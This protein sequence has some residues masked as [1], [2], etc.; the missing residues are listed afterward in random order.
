MLC[1]TLGFCVLTALVGV[2]AN[3]VVDGSERVVVVMWMTGLMY[4][5]CQEGNLQMSDLESELPR[6][7]SW[8]FLDE[9]PAGFI[10]FHY[11]GEMIKSEDY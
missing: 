2:G 7:K 1:F 4:S 11:F 6:R 10:I 8:E 5:H 3:M 9:M